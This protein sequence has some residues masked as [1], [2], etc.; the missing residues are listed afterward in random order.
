M[1]GPVV[2]EGYRDVMRALTHAERD[3]RLGVR[4]ELRQI[5]EPVKADEQAT[6]LTAFR[7]MP[8]SPQWARMRIGVT[9]NEVYVVPSRKGARGRGRH[10]RPRWADQFTTRVKQPVTDRHQAT[11]ERQIEQALDRIADRFNRGS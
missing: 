2:V 11:F 1:A 5:A 6:T 3:V 7:N 8:R 4:K 10:S 9:R